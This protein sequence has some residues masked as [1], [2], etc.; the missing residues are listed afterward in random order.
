MSSSFYYFY[1]P[2]ERD[3]FASA[4]FLLHPSRE[5]GG[6]LVLSTART[7]STLTTTTVYT[8]PGDFFRPLPPLPLEP[9]FPFS[10]CFPFFPEPFLPAYDMFI[11]PEDAVVDGLNSAALPCSLSI[12]SVAGSGCPPPE[13]AEE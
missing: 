13:V 1:S 6:L 8:S 12:M 10:P 7:S 9:R 3:H 5:P 4:N 2:R 11:T